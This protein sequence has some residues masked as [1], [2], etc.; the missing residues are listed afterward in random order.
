MAKQKNFVEE[1]TSMD[2]DFAKWYTDVVKKK[3]IW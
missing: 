3:Q 1:I 2:Q